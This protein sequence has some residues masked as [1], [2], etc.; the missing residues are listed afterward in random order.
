ML[1]VSCDPGY[2]L[3]GIDLGAQDLTATANAFGYNQVPPIDLP[4]A[5]A[6]FFP[7]ESNLAANPPFLAYSAIGQEDVRQPRCRM[8]S[9][10]L[11]SPMVGRS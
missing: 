5:V 2:A 3:L 8:R 1:P 7:T 6:S 4:G 11:A 10:R 9:S